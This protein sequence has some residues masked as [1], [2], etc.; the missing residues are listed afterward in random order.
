MLGGV[1]LTD[2]YGWAQQ[3]GAALTDLGQPPAASPWRLA[4]VQDPDG[5]PR[6]EVAAAVAELRAA[7]DAL[8]AHAETAALTRLLEPSE[9][10]ELVAWLVTVENGTAWPPVVAAG[11]AAGSPS[12]PWA[13]E[14]KRRTDAVAQFRARAATELGPFRAGSLDLPTEALLAR[15][16]QA[17]AKFFGKKRLRRQLLA[18]LEPTLQDDIALPGSPQ[19]CSGSTSSVAPAR[20]CAPTSRSSRA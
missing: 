6:E 9:L 3:L 2:L 12:G 13:D 10:D 4:G 20:T 17:D 18:E 19:P 11:V 8:T 7:R 15:S 14:A 1:Q 5:L 16:A